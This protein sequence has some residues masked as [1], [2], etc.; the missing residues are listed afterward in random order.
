VLLCSSGEVGPTPAADWIWGLASYL[1]FTFPALV[2]DRVRWLMAVMVVGMVVVES[3][4]TLVQAFVQSCSRH[5]WQPPPP[6]ME[7]QRVLF[8]Q[9]EAQGPFGA[10]VLGASMVGV[11]TGTAGQ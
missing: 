9:W 8:L 2:V 7:Q 11:P 3:P 10:A 5:I 4:F 6:P 1:L